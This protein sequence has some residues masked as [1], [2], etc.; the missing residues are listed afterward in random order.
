ML[1]GSTSAFDGYGAGEAAGADAGKLGDRLLACVTTAFPT[2]PVSKS[3]VE[4][5][6][7]DHV[8]LIIDDAYAFRFPRA[9]MHDLAF[10]IEVLKLVQRAGI[11]PTPAYD[12]I[13]PAGRFAGYRFIEG[14]EL[15]QFRF[16]ALAA[17]AQDEIISTAA[18][19]LSEL[20]G[21]SVASVS[22]PGTWPA[23]WTAAQFAHRGLTERLPLIA[24]RVPSLAGSIQ[25]FFCRYQDD[26]P[27]RLVIVH[28]DLIADH[29]LLDER[30][31]QLAGIIDF[32][33][34]ALGDPAQDF[35]GLWIYGSDAASRAVELYRSRTVD[36]GLL[37]R[38]RNHFIRYRIDQLF[39]RLSGSGR[40]EIAAEA[41]EI[42][43]L[44]SQTAALN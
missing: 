30:S 41:A 10:E 39:E 23:S 16:A 22:W 27:D 15:S 43:A 1:L 19:F 42:G 21:I 2:L 20:H 14:V 18:Q 32:G 40:V 29:F 31:G 5:T 26:R 12:L 4:S 44:L 35:L 11:V 3:R 37:C 28:G 33:D 24:A 25:Q 6:G 34:V 9:D 8:L 36:R 7:G 38:S 17:S 13:D